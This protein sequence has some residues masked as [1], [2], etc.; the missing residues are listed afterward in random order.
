MFYVCIIQSLVTGHY[1]IGQTND[2]ESRIDRHNKG[3]EKYTS[4]YLPWKLIWSTNKT[5][6]AEAMQLE[7][8]LKNLSRKRLSDFVKKYSGSSNA[9]EV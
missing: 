1:Y 5:T 4:K 8:K 9:D 3:I 6:R 7:R 2:I